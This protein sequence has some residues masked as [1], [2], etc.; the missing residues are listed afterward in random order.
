MKQL[1]TEKFSRRLICLFVSI[2]FTVAVGSVSA[3]VVVTDDITADTIWE[4]E[5]TYLLDGLIFVDNGATLTIEPGTVIKGLEQT[6]ITTGDGASA[7]IIRRGAR[8]IADGTKEEPIIFTSELDDVDD[9][10]DLTHTDRGLWG[11]VILLGEAPTNQSES[12]TQIEGIPAEIEAR[13]GG[14]DPN[15]DSGVLRYISIR[16]GGFSISGVEGDEINGL[17]MGAV[18]NGTTIEYVEVFANFDDCF[19]WFGGTVNTKYLVGAFC[20]D[21]TF[22]YDQGYRGMGQFWFSIHNN[23][24]A[25]RGGEHDGCDP[26]TGVCDDEGFSQVIVSNATFIGAGEDAAVAGGDNNDTTFRLRENVGA[27]YYNSIFTDFPG[28]AIRIDTDDT[29]PDGGDR[30]NA[31]DIEFT[32]N[33]F[34]GYGADAGAPET[35]ESIVQSSDAIQPLLVAALSA[36]NSVEDPV[37]AGISRNAGSQA[38]DPRPGEGS[39]APGMATGFTDGDD[40]EEL[41]SDFFTPV[42]FIG[43]FG[44]DLWLFNWTALDRHGFI[45]DLT[46]TAI[47][48]VDSE[49]PHSIS[50]EQNYPNPFNPSTMITFALDRQQHIRL[51]IY[52]LMGR[53]VDVLIDGIHPA[54][55]F[56]IDFVATGLSTGMYL[57]RLQTESETFTRTMTLIR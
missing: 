57:Y 24:T 50:L 15:D 7:L 12:L 14:N 45:G 29:E 20:G 9:P 32:N 18:G 25:G 19:E 33:I 10:D 17:T 40:I 30:F 55:N 41:E 13:Y 48:V 49:I 52:D 21:D 51:A 26:E 23:D 38:L 53:E 8:L 27:K 54:G 28:L 43:A 1:F 56:R 4:S 39:P 47:E 31:G 16:H 44:T 22:D 2:S 3:Q 5:N 42:D 34:Y 11:G 35:F 46:S 37:L 6:N 36:N